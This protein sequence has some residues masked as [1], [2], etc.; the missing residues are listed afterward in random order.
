MCREW[1]ANGKPVVTWG[2]PVKAIGNQTQNPAQEK[3]YTQ[4]RGFSLIHARV[5]PV[6]VR[7][8]ALACV[9]SR[10]RVWAIQRVRVCACCY[11]WESD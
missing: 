7:V 1:K 11:P 3:C 5:S 8:C 6:G 10:V 4:A 9:R 2:K